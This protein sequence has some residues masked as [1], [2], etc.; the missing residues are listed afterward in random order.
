MIV[1]IIYQENDPE[2]E[3]IK[4]IV[5]MINNVQ[6]YY[7]LILDTDESPNTK[8]LFGATVIG[9]E[10]ID[11][12]CNRRREK[13]TIYICG[14]RFAD[15]WFAHEDRSASIITYNSWN[16]LYAPPSLKSY[17]IFEIVQS[18]INYAAD[19]NEYVLLRR[20]VHEQPT[21][22]MNDMCENKEE[23]KIGISAGFICPS[24]RSVYRQYGV[25][26]EAILSIEKILEI[27]RCEALGKNL[28]KE[29][30]RNEK[31][32][33]IVHGHNTEILE[34]VNGYLF[35]LGL[36]PIILKYAARLG[37]DSILNQISLNSDVACAILIFTAD[38]KGRGKD[39]AG[40]KYNNRARQNVVFEAGYFVGCLGKERVLMMSER[41]IELPSDLGGCRY[42]ELKV[43]QIP[44]LY[45]AAI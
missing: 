21:G 3:T 15:N 11:E 19:I 36:D 2:E 5:R 40:T 43:S 33:F 27:S 45:M 39:D 12:I 38:D 24:C 37:I 35:E 8:K 44:V 41:N 26:E 6:S 9:K 7:H 10:I 30:Y 1:A 22:C 29:A 31:K 16:E 25:S 4:S 20:L 18:L 17:L 42:I 32:V 23:I 34:K 28:P 13:K 14:R